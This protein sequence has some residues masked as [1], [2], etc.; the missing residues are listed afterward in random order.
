MLN[1]VNKSTL[2]TPF[3]YTKIPEE[4]GLIDSLEANYDPYKL[5]CLRTR[6]LPILQSTLGIAADY[7]INPINGSDNIIHITL[8]LVFNGEY[9]IIDNQ[10]LVL[11]QQKVNKITSYK[12]NY[13]LIFKSL[14]LYYDD[15]TIVPSEWVSNML[16]LI[17][18]DQQIFHYIED[19][20]VYG[21]L[22]NFDNLYNEIYKVLQNEIKFTLLD[23]YENGYVLNPPEHIITAWSLEPVST[24]TYIKYNE[25]AKYVTM[26]KYEPTNNKVY[27]TKWQDNRLLLQGQKLSSFILSRIEDNFTLILP[28]NSRLYNWVVKHM[29][30][31]IIRHYIEHIVNINFTDDNLTLII[32]NDIGFT[33]D[34]CQL[35]LSSIDIAKSLAFGK[36][37]FLSSESNK[38]IN[39]Y[40]KIAQQ[41]GMEDIQIYNDNISQHV[42]TILTSIDTDTN[43]LEQQIIKQG[44]MTICG[45]NKNL[46]EL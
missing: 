40:R 35:I 15:G 38:I 2:K 36:I 12:Q 19:D 31:K 33:Y 26:K 25:F 11:L 5:F 28:F 23:I 8:D 34:M 32:N 24:V 14:N 22:R 6:L 17:T 37:I 9:I 44:Y 39:N 16:Q 30:V 10:Q 27:R 46:I 4:N 43:F 1:K 3:W 41:L 45:V 13:C 20:C 29:V 18:F 21:N 7:Y 42:M